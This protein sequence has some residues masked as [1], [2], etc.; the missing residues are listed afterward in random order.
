MTK[1]AARPIYDKKKK[2]LNFSS[3]EPFADFIE[4]GFTTSATQVLPGLLK[5]DP[6]LTFDL[7]TWISTFSGNASPRRS[8][9]FKQA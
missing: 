3:S 4:T 5:D 1:I 7:F 8:D 6:R 9:I 2:P